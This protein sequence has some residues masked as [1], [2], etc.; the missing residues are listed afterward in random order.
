MKSSKKKKA[1][2]NKAAEKQKEELAKNSKKIED[3]INRIN[4]ARRDGNLHQ[5]K[6]LVKELQ[7][8]LKKTGEGAIVA[9]NRLVIIKAR[10]LF[11]GLFNKRRS[12][13]EDTYN[14]LVALLDKV[15]IIED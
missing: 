1:E 15:K 4:A 9:L 8:A 10:G 14:K 2:E 7:E 13:D 3:L 5:V 12:I 11:N 6:R